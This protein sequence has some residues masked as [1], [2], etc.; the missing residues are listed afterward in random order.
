MIKKK[1]KKQKKEKKKS[2]KFIKNEI[3]VSN[4]E[5][6]ISEWIPPSDK[7]YRDLNTHSWYNHKIFFNPD[8]QIVD[9]YKKIAPSELTKDSQFISVKKIRLYPTFNQKFILDQWFNAFAKMFNIT[10]NYLRSQIKINK[11]LDFFQALK[12]ANFISVRG[13]LKEK[14]KE[15]IE[16]M[17]KFKIPVHILDEAVNQAV[18]NYKTSL[19]NLKNNIIRKFRVREWNMNKR[20]KIIKIESSFFRNGTFCSRTFPVMASSE[21]LNDINKTCTL[22]FDR[23][24][25]KY[26]LLVPYDV[27][28]KEITKKKIS[29]GIDLG[30]RSF[31][32]VYSHKSTH[33]ICEESY[34]NPSIYNCINKIDKLNDLL[35]VNKE[36]ENWKKRTLLKKALI[37]YHRKIN[38]KIKD[39]HY[40]VS[41]KLVNK[42]DNIYIGK[43]N[44]LKILSKSNITISRKVKRTIGML[45]PYKFRETLKYMGDKYGTTVIEVNEY[46]TTKT[47]SE[48]GRTNEIG[49]SK[50]HKCKCGMEA[51][52][53]ENAAKNIMKVGMK[54]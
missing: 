19:T 34:K 12:I 11:N 1:K 47:C 29:C 50:I 31:A 3:Y 43:L 16:S 42:Y 32:T 48:C 20:R 4:K 33:S 37:K 25:K 6:G 13:L 22:I 7:K 45:A 23:D 5:L 17:G 10:V 21:P 27:E 52:R 39:M 53:D 9:K 8:E 46:M 54:N 18:S 26:I 44:T 36:N 35:N 28:K 24:T 14:S 40:K 2:N 15:L 38:N 49:K 41:H 30:V 51:D